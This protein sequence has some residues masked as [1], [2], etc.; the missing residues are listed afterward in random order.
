M[1]LQ[2]IRSMVELGKKH[3]YT[4]MDLLGSKNPAIQNVTHYVMGGGRPKLANLTD[5]QID[6]M[7]RA[8][9]WRTQNQ[10]ADAT[11]A[12]TSP[13][14]YERWARAAGHEPYTWNPLEPA[15]I[16]GA[17]NNPKYTE[18]RRTLHNTTRKLMRSAPKQSLDYTG[19]GTSTF[20]V[21]IY[22]R[23]ERRR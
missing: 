11:P 12:V 21:D 13:A 16:E 6:W 18:Q 3:G 1:S 23:G 2:F 5:E 17:G 8:A 15:I 7:I 20:P 10:T 19:S 14:L 9:D 22:R 4:P